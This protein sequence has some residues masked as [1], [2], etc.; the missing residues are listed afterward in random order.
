MDGE[1]SKHDTPS[2]VRKA[3]TSH[4]EI[5]SYP[6]TNTMRQLLGGKECLPTIVWYC[7]AAV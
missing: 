3:E 5:S 2:E 6:L 1:T 4:L 7:P